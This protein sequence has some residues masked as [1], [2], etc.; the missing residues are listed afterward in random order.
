MSRPTNGVTT[1]NQR[2]GCGTGRGGPAGRSAAPEEI[3]SAISYLAGDQASFV[4]GAG[5]D[6]DGGRRAA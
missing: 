4:H 6:V 1:A 3:A 5:L 2:G